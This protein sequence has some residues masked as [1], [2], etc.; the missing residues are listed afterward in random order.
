MEIYKCDRCGK[1]I[2]RKSRFLGRING[3]MSDLC[4]VCF[5]EFKKDRAL[6]ESMY[7]KQINAICVKYGLTSI[8]EMITK[9]DK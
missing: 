2:D 9:E 8:A 4:P 6:A 3:M 5:E 1:I 7:E